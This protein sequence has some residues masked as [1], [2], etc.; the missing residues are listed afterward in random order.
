[1]K[2]L[3]DAPGA[4]SRGSCCVI[5]SPGLKV[6]AKPDH[7]NSINFIVLVR[8]SAAVLLSGLLMVIL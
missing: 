2:L 3:C 7:F 8:W 1:M 6:G 4:K 5:I